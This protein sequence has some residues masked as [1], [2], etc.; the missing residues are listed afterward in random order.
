MTQTYAIHELLPYVNWTFFFI[1]WG[2]KARY[3]VIEEI[4]AA[5]DCPA[6]RENWIASFSTEEERAEAR[7]ALRLYTDA[8]VYLRRLEADGVRTHCVFELFPAYSEGDDIVA[9]RPDGTSLVLPFLR[10][11]HGDPARPHLCLSDYIGPRGY[12]DP[13]RVGDHLGGFATTVD[14]PSPSEDPYEQMLIQVLLDRLAEAAAE[15]L[16]QDIRIRFWGFAPEEQLDKAAL[17]AEQ[18]QGIRPAVGYP[19]I[20]DQSFN[21]LLYELIPMK[22][23]GISLTENGMMYPHASVSGLIFSHPAAR[24]FA[25]GAV[26]DEQLADYA[27]RRGTTLEKMRKFVPRS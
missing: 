7:E 4:L 3:A 2:I 14:V 19:S 26:S 21:F 16:H 5:H 6:C 18:Y 10:Q 23:I 24:Y 25:V 27:A 15:K 8:Q 22:E 20:P 1:P 9:I 11:Q 13:E 17:L 12:T